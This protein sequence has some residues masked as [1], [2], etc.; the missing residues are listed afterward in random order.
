[1]HNVSSDPAT[2]R[3]AIA[4]ND[5]SCPASDST[6]SQVVDRADVSPSFN[7]T[8]PEHSQSFTDA[9]T[10]TVGSQESSTQLQPET[11]PPQSQEAPSSQRSQEGL[12][13]MAHSFASSV[14]YLANR[15]NL[16]SSFSTPSTLG[17]GRDDSLK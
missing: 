5:G 2:C 13:A 17:R 3:S 9:V 15:W 14:G 7:H 4:D 10:P 6:S 11:T 8:S 12:E 16:G 1:M